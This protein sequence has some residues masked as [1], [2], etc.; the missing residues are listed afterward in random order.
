MKP[1]PHVGK[2]PNESRRQRLHVGPYHSLKHASGT[3][4][5][6]HPNCQTELPQLLGISTFKN[7][8]CVVILRVAPSSLGRYRW[9]GKPCVRRCAG[10]I[11]AFT[12]S[13]LSRC[14]GPGRGSAGPGVEQRAAHSPGHGDLRQSSWHPESACD[15][16]CEPER[17]LIYERN[18]SE[19]ETGSCGPWHLEALHKGLLNSEWTASWSS[20]RRSQQQQPRRMLLRACSTSRSLK[21]RLCAYSLIISITPAASPFVCSR[22]SVW[23]PQMLQR[24]ARWC[25][26]PDEDAV[27]QTPPSLD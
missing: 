23:I 15:G 9:L 19:G 24:G 22:P 13:S 12:Q 1:E 10:V 21:Y 27:Q 4:G 17:F 6:A 3:G 25:P 2:R 18:Y 16:A 8:N 14:C 20:R 26:E 5:G 11:D 7:K